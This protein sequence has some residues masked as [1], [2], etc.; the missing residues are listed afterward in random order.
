MRLVAPDVVDFFLVDA[1]VVQ[2]LVDC[3]PKTNSNIAAVVSD[4]VS[5]N[6]NARERQL[7]LGGGRTLSLLIDDKAASDR[8]VLVRRHQR[9]F[10]V[11]HGKPHPVRVGGERIHAP[12]HVPVV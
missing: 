4:S 7:G 3:A 9:P 10:L 11:K 12:E 6:G 8:K 5:P 2:V 1:A